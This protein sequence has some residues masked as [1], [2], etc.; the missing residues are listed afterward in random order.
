MRLSR[1]QTL[2]ILATA[3]PAILRPR[4]RAAEPIKWLTLSGHS[5]MAPLVGQDTGQF[6]RHGLTVQAG[7]STAPPTL[8][9][10]VVSGT[11]QVGTSTGVQLALAHEAGLDIVALSGAAV[12]MQGHTTAALVIRP[13]LSIASA[14]DFIGR[15]VVSPGTNGSFHLMFVKYLLDRGVDP[16]GVTM[17]E[18]AF[19]QMADMLRAGQADAVLISEPYT[20]RL[21]DAGIGTRMEYY[22]VEHGSVCDSFYI[23][24]QKWAT[25]NPDTLAALRQALRETVAL[26]AADPARAAE[27]EVKYTRLPIETINRLGV[28]AARVDLTAA[29]MQVWIDIGRQVKLLTQDI[30]PASLIAH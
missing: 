9:P 30:D 6:A 11:L 19:P 7:I 14:R 4:A 18:A 25:A 2:A 23:C 16:A 22:P 27:I 29:D 26:M 3:G 1:R 24:S 20:T 21:M 12:Q 13:G 28:A 10:A 5:Y 8:L 15:K 17:M